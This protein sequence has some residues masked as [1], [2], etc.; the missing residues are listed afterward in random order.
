MTRVLI[1]QI[2]N[3]RSKPGDKVG[4]FSSPKIEVGERYRDGQLSPSTTRV[5]QNHSSS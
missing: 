2:I 1:V 4:A 5:L 3:C